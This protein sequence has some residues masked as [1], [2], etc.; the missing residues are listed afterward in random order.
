MGGRGSSSRF[1]KPLSIQEVKQLTKNLTSA[2]TAET[3]AY[4][5][6]QLAMGAVHVTPDD[7]PDLLQARREAANKAHSKY[8]AAQEKR[9][10]I[11]KAIEKHRKSIKV[12]SDTPF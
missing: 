4:K 12:N 6:Y 11:E 3:R 9:I 2:K 7:K 1:T 5:Q 10:S 8:V